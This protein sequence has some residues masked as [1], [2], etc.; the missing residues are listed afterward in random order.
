MGRRPE[1]PFLS[2]YQPRRRAEPTRARKIGTRVLIGVL[3]LSLV[4]GAVG[5]YFYK[6]FEGNITQLDIT[7]DLGKDRP[8]RLDTG[9]KSALNVLVMGSDTRKGK[10]NHIAGE[11]PGLSDTTILLHLSKD[12]SRAYGVSIPRDAMVER[13]T[14]EKKDHSGTVAGG[15]TQFNAAYEVGGPACTIKTVESITKVFIDHFVVVDF[16][17]FKKMVDALGGVKVCVP[18]EVDDTVG[19]IH[20][21]AGTYNVTGDQALDY[22][23]VR[24]GISANGD[25]G[26]MKR[27]QT[28]IAA[29]INKA[30]SAGTLANPVKLVRFLDA[31]TK[32]LTTDPGFAHLKALASL[33]SSLKNIGLDKITFVT[34]PFEPYAPDPNRLQLS[35]DANALW[36][37][38]R[39][40]QELGPKFT[41]EVVKASDSTPGTKTSPLSKAP[42]TAAD[43]GTGKLKNSD[44]ISADERNRIAAEN[45]LCA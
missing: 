45:G 5:V 13:P 21:A 35:P 6:R 36:Q 17:G 28:F 30:V 22:V 38:I 19:N 4:L 10:G 24:H 31:A 33:G 39:A 18:N 23:R 7:K 11:T 16:N 42:A 32:S 37:E 12:R 9:P 25:I 44:T 20:L 34:A 43:A 41:G 14:C 2:Q 8:K 1:V 15:L 3:S 26:R 40:D 27:Q 29:M